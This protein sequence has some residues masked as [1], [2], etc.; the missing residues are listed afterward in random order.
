MSFMDIKRITQLFSEDFY[1]FPW[2]ELGTMGTYRRGLD[3]YLKYKIF[4]V[5]I[6]A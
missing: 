5:K 2:N 4:Y 1:L 6:W 3:K